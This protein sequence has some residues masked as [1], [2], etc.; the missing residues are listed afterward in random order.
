[1]HSDF[2]RRLSS[3]AEEMAITLIFSFQLIRLR[4]ER[5][6]V[7]I[8][9]SVTQPR[10]L[11][12]AC[13]NFPIYS[14]TFVYQEITQLIRKGFKV[15]FFYH[16]LNSRDQ[17]P[18][19]FQSLWRAKHKVMFNTS[20]CNRNFDYFKKKWPDKVDSLIE[21]LCQASGMSHADLKNHHH[22]LQSFTFTR[23]AEAYKP[24]YLHSYFFYE[25]TFFAAVAAYLLNIPRGVSCYA[26]HL[27][28]DYELK[29]VPF[30]L[31]KCKLVIA[32]SNRIKRE[33]TGIT[34]KV[35]PERILVKPNAINVVA[36]PE[37]SFR[38]PEDSQPYQ[39][40][41]VSRIEPKKGL[42]YL[43]DAIRMLRARDLNVELRLI[44]GVDQSQSSEEYAR[45]LANRI[46][47]HKL[48]KAVSLKG[49][50]SESEIKSFFKASHLFVAP[51]IETESGDKD[52]I[53]TSLLEAMSSG[54]PVV[55]TDAGSI[56]EV[57]DNGRD[58][59]IVPQR[60]SGAL[61]TAIADLINDRELRV[62][63]GKNA[64]E[65]IRTKFDVTV[66][67]HLFHDRIAEILNE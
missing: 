7:S 51:F 40:V 36:F 14:N 9:S 65:K 45:N 20:V 54:L 29:I 57:I 26:D 12:T 46:K 42:I 33:L 2:F 44:G 27:L 61:A 5:W 24:D 52:G 11:L 60:D 28:D 30:Q 32:T 3:W 37:M 62:R 59:V 35:D 8:L 50:K 64:A 13:W 4:T 47:K 21:R 41:C 53:P 16:Q 31:E 19:Q 34:S 63:L 22:F 58:G 15:R 39:L 25:G 38:E 10:A 6:Y 55:A 18:E 66:C 17:L 48:D 49:R 1:M 67:E 43:V 56:L 23:L